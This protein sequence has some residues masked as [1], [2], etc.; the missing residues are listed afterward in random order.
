MKILIYIILAL[1]LCAC[2]KSNCTISDKIFAF[3]EDS[4]AHQTINEMLRKKF[5]ELKT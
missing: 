5:A 2:T 4:A 3:K 1:S